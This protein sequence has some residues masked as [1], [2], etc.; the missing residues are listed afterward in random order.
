MTNLLLGKNPDGS[1][2][3]TFDTLAGS[4]RYNVYFGR[5]ATVRA[6]AYDHGAGAPAGP[7]CGAPTSPAGAGRLAATVPAAQQPSV[8]A[9]VLVTGHVDDVESPSG[10]ATGS[11]EID[12]SQSICM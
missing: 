3:A 7:L 11:V 10:T 4:A 1:L 2:A 9:Y 8:D 6:G 5:L 12:R